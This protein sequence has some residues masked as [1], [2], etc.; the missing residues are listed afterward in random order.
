MARL[1]LVSHGS[2]ISGRLDRRDFLAALGGSAYGLSFAGLLAGCS[3]A[4]PEPLAPDGGEIRGN[5][6]DF[7][8]GE[9]QAVG[10]IFLMY[11]SGL[12]TG[13][14]VD[15][16]MDATF[17]FPNV[18]P[19]E[20]QLRFHAPR[21][22]QVPP[23]LNNPVRATVTEREVTE[24]TFRI[25][26]GEF[27]ENMIE[28]YVGDD[29]FQEQP[30]GEPNK[31]TTIGVGVIVCWYNVGDHLHNVVG[32]PWGNSGDMHSTDSFIWQADQVGEF[33]YQCTYHQ[34]QM[35]SSLVVE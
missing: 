17:R 28:I 30:Y 21:V 31:P 13:R 1:P 15:V 22:A 14:Y 2:I 20:Y 11:G 29:F 12:Q 23:H 26:L 8:T 16:G 27:N 34:P 4:A 32:E 10:R 3:E 6:L 24:A 25:E 33:Q 7:T 19:G 18:A 5:V 9:P 35:R